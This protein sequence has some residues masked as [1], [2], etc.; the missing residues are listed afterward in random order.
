MPVVVTQP[1]R[2]SFRRCRRQWDLRARMRRGLEPVAPPAGPDLAAAVHAALAVYYFPGMWDWDR[3]ITIPLVLQAFDDEIGRQRD[4]RPAGDAAPDWP[5]LLAAGHDMLHRYAAWAHGADRFSPV[6][7]DADYEVQVPDPVRPGSGLTGGNRQPVRFRGRIDMLAVDEFDAYWLVRHTLRDGSWLATGEL[8]SDE[9]ALADAWAW[10]QFYPGMAIAGTIY[11]ELRPGAGDPAPAGPPDAG[12]RAPSGRRDRR[13]RWRRGRAEPAAG[14]PG[15]VRPA[16]AGS[17]PLVR[18]HE[19]SGGGRSIPQHRRMDARAREP[20]PAE[21]AGPIS[22]IQEISP[23]DRVSPDGF[24]RTWVRH[25]PAA[26]TAAGE[27]LA[28]DAAAMLAAGPSAPPNPS[29][30]NCR[31]CEFLPP[32]LAMRAGRD[33]EF[34]IRSGY[35]PRPPDALEEGRLGGG[36]WGTGR[37]AAPFRRRG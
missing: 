30:A 13:P 34:L 3:T 7:I 14:L 27:Q 17:P 36:S 2:E 19:P 26:V 32:C 18:Q 5:R 24:R 15:P 23:D 28:A 10:E 29:D 9:A 1:D 37:G 6:L 12:G 25:S 16:G 11:T 33:S 35:R 22:T 21:P 31:P 20:A 8:T 4:R